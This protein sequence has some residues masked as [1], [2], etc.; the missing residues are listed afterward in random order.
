MCLDTELLIPLH[1]HMH[2]FALDFMYLRSVKIRAY[3]PQSVSFS[4]SISLKL[5]I[6][7]F[8]LQLLQ[9]SLVMEDTVTVAMITWRL[10]LEE[11]D[12]VCNV[13]FSGATVT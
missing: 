8:S 1:R 10:L 6:C 5:L 9:G 3:P 12:R 7:S 4:L 2:I 11:S 13:F